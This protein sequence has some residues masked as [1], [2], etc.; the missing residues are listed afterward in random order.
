MGFIFHQ[1]AER[2]RI[3]KVRRLLDD[4]VRRGPNAYR[5]FIQVLNAT[6]YKFL[7]DKILQ[8]EDI[9]RREKEPNTSFPVQATNEIFSEI[10]PSSISGGFATSN[11]NNNARNSLIGPVNNNMQQNPV[12][13]GSSESNLSSNLS[14]VS[15]SCSERNSK[16]GVG[17][18]TVHEM[19][20]FLNM[21][22]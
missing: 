2:T 18:L 3:D 17:G 5:A 15:Q 8:N 9:V 22:E 21:K 1:Q 14:S 6:G 7:A 19:G 13:L 20:K 11:L 10:H 12:S 4:L 16:T